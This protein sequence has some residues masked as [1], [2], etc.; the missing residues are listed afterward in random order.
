MASSLEGSSQISAFT[1]S[2][3]VSLAVT[4]PSYFVPI[5]SALDRP[6]HSQE[7][8]QLPGN[9]KGRALPLICSASP[10]RAWALLWIRFSQNWRWRQVAP[11]FIPTNLKTAGEMAQ[12]S[13]S[14]NIVHNIVWLSVTS[15]VLMLCLVKRIGSSFSV[16]QRCF[17]LSAVPG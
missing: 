17:S 14:H 5:V 8:S 15:G 7:W 10:R 13:S 3:S 1:S 2:S 16:C 4:K 6:T 11:A 12:Q 9:V